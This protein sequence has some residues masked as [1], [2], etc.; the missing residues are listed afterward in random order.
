MKEERELKRTVKRG[1]LLSAISFAAVFALFRFV[2]GLVYIPTSSMEPT[3]RAGS[4]GIAWRLGF[5]VRDETEI[6]RGDIIVFQSEE[7]GKCLC[8][9]V[10]GLPGET[11][12]I[13]NGRVYIDGKVLE[14][15]YLMQ[16]NGT[17]SVKN[18]FEVPEGS[19]FV[20]GDNRFHSND[21][22]AWGDPYVEMGS[23]RMKWVFPK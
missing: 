8:K 10:I 18:S 4:I 7:T 1:V 15:D 9:R 16:Q 13:E 3:I 12:T 21:S 14:E 17:Y 23:I 6:K 2:F 5:I 11:V 19:V 22:R 20:M